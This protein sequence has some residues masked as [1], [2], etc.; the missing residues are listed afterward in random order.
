VEHVP[1][2]YEDLYLA[3][4]E[5]ILSAAA[6]APAR[7]ASMHEEEYRVVRPEGVIRVRIDRV[8]RHGD[9]P[10]VAVRYRSGRARDEHR[11]DYRTAL[12][13]AALHAEHG[14]GDVHQQYLGANMIDASQARSATLE[15]RLR[16][17][18]AAL[19][20]IARAEFA[21]RPGEQC[22]S[23]PFWLICPAG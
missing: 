18:D 10:P 6:G 16:E 19:A 1:H 12:Y 13:R 17:C 4:A 22:R 20:G 14:A 2:P 7:A 11:R 23:C 9:A 3:R 5:R 8:D 21:P 15:A